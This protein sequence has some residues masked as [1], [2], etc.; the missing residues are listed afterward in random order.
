MESNRPDHESSYIEGPVSKLGRPFSAEQLKKH[1][2]ESVAAA[3]FDD[4]E[5]RREM[6]DNIEN[7]ANEK[8]EIADVICSES[9]ASQES[10]TGQPFNDARNAERQYEEC[11]RRTADLVPAEREL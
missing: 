3:G 10:Q 2:E 11:C 1:I 7:F 9:P 4:D 6:L 8:A 5:V